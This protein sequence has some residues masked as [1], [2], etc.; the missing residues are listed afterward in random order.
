MISYEAYINTKN[1]IK[2]GFKVNKHPN[3]FQY[4]EL[5]GPEN[6]HLQVGLTSGG[7]R[8]LELCDDIKVS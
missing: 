3:S 4:E 7:H 2:H 6:Y 1:P 8:I 5:E